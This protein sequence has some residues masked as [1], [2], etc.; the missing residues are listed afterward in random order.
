MRERVVEGGD[1]YFKSLES[2]P[3]ACHICG[4]VTRV[5]IIDN[6]TEMELPFCVRC[7]AV[8]KDGW[9]QW[10]TRARGMVQALGKGPKE[11]SE[12]I[13]LFSD[14][15]LSLKKEGFTSRLAN[16]RGVSYYRK[17][18]K[19]FVHVDETQIEEV[20]FY[21]PTVDQLIDLNDLILTFW[22][23]DLSKRPMVYEI[24]FAA[25]LYESRLVELLTEELQ[26]KVLVLIE[27]IPEEVLNSLDTKLTYEERARALGFSYKDRSFKTYWKTHGWINK[28]LASLLTK[29]GMFSQAQQVDAIGKRFDIIL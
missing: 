18:H 10:E 6:E 4:Q 3:F 14:E 22:E 28:H 1:F 2:E 7:E 21:H 17:Y 29:C 19:L 26:E 23:K 12:S 9:K 5:S 27:N 15:V 25:L 20:E 11:V 13:S 8:P 24:L 16:H